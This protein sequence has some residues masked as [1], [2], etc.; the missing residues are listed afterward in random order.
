VLS[1]SALLRGGA[2]RRAAN[3][4]GAALSSAL[5][6]CAAGVG[7]P[8]AARRSARRQAANDKARELGLGEVGGFGRFA[9]G[10]AI[11][12]KRQSGVAMAL[13]ICIAP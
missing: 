13:H 7:A 11:N 8:A 6:I 2:R 4:P 10:F 9:Y 5:P 3:V 12:A 1:G